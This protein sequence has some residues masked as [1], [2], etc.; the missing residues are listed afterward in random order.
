MQSIP[1]ST[2]NPSIIWVLPPALG[3]TVDFWVGPAD[4]YFTGQAWPTAPGY[5]W[6][7]L[8]IQGDFPQFGANYT[9]WILV[10]TTNNQL[11]YGKTI[12]VTGSGDQLSFNGAVFNFYYAAL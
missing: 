2:G 1:D 6:V 11:Q 4:P 3:V 9:D 12:T 5:F 8:P 10:D 7:P